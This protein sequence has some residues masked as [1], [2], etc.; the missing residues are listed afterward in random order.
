MHQNITEDL[1]NVIP[2]RKNFD[3][4]NCSPQTDSNGIKSGGRGDHLNFN[5]LRLGNG[6]TNQGQIWGGGLEW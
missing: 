3:L 2:T 5:P 4:V 6:S 1:P